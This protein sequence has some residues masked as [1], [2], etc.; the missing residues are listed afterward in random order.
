MD[1]G[2]RA[3]TG[4]VWYVAYGSN[5]LADRFGCYVGGGRPPG[6][7]REYPGF[8]DPTPPRASTPLTIPGGIY[9]A[10]DSHAWTGGTAFFDSEISG[11]VAA[12][13]YLIGADQFVDLAEQEMLRDPA[14]D[15]DLST[16]LADGRHSYGP[17]RY[18]SWIRVGERDGMPML[19]ISAPWGW[20][21]A[22]LSPPN[23][24][25][26]RIIGHGLIEAHGWG[27]DQAA[28]YLASAPGANGEW[29]TSQVENLLG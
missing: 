16:V 11:V 24:D 18:E 2:V 21:A 7:L 9:F 6:G 14:V 8:R 19:T 25:Y 26:L 12:R 15:R 23:A 5:L 28:E 20:T 17:G 29:Q 22:P 3:Q 10:G 4:P 13:A 27:A 1:D